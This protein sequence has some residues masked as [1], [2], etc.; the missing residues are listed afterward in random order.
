MF[1]A[2]MVHAVGQTRGSFNEP[3]RKRDLD[4]AFV[5]YSKEGDIIYRESSGATGAD[6]FATSITMSKTSGHL[7]IAGAS[8][9]QYWMGE[10]GMLLLEYNRHIDATE[11]LPE[12]RGMNLGGFV[13]NSTVFADGNSIDGAA[14]ILGSGNEAKDGALLYRMRDGVLEWKLPLRHKTIAIRSS[15]V[16]VDHN[17]LPVVLTTR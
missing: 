17:S 5:Q 10:P 15:D 6:D 13:S 3:R 8:H 7:L 12:V 16:A 4:F 9:G 14:Y 11:A 2:G 1:N